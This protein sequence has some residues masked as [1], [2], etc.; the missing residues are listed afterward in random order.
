MPSAGEPDVPIQA[1]RR[2]DP[3]IR[4]GVAFSRP[5]ASDGVR[6]SARC[7]LAAAAGLAIAD[8]FHLPFPLYAVIAAVI[9]TDLSA[10]ETRRLAAS[11]IG[12]TMVG[13]VLGA[14]L[15][16]VLPT[17]PLAIASGIFLAMALTHALHMPA[18]A[19]LSGYVCAI[20]LVQQSAAP[21]VYSWWRLAETVVGIAVAVLMSFVPMLLP[22]PTKKT[23]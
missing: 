22:A 18:A 1:S 5:S 20:C 3:A 21:W 23:P 17:G 10:A 16:P 15:S 11:R 6:C 9:V 13:A 8:L 12:G 19:K 4:F 14:A 2:T 7:A